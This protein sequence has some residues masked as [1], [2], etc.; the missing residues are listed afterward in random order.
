[1]IDTSAFPNA[2][3]LGL[4]DRGQIMGGYLDPDGKVDGQLR[5]AKGS[6]TTF[7]VPQAVPD[8]GVGHHRSTPD[9]RHLPVSGAGQRCAAVY[10]DSTGTSC[11]VRARTTTRATASAR[12]ANT[13]A[14]WNEVEMPWARTWSAQG[15]GSW[16]VC[17]N[18][19]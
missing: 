14:S 2:Q 8:R 6:F 10:E 9:C 15:A 17:W 18:W 16:P 4:N 3:L 7:F 12:A 13:T 1:V 5:D 19:A 11:G